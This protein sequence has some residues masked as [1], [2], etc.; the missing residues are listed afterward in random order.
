MLDQTKAEIRPTRVRR[1]NKSIVVT[2]PMRVCE[3]LGLKP[4]DWVVIVDNG[5]H[6]VGRKVDISRVIRSMDGKDER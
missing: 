1:E 5:H 2:I 4:G 3:S 6:F